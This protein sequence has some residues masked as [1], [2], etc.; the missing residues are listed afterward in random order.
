MRTKFLTAVLLGVL[1]CACTSQ[2]P[3]TSQPPAATEAAPAPAA[4]P[5]APAATPGHLQPAPQ[6]APR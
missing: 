1:A 3:A 6:A 2:T 4:E 5:A